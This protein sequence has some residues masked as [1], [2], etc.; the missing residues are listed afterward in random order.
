MADN[1]LQRLNSLCKS[2]KESLEQE[3]V[4]K[5][6]HEEDGQKLEDGKE[7]FGFKDSLSQPVFWKKSRKKKKAQKLLKRNLRLVLV[8]EGNGHF[9]S[10]FVFR[11][12]QQHIQIFNDRIYELAKE[13][14]GKRNP[15]KDDIAF[16]EAQF[17]G[18]FKNGTPLTLAKKPKKNPQ[19][20]FKKFNHFDIL[21]S[22]GKDDYFK[23]LEGEK[24]PFH[25]HIRK[26]NPRDK[27]FQ[28]SDQPYSGSADPDN[29]QNKIEV[30]IV[31]RG[32]PYIESD[33]KKGI[34][35][36][37]YQASLEHQFV[38][39][40]RQWVNWPDFP[41]N[42]NGQDPLLAKGRESLFTPVAKFRQD[43]NKSWNENE[44]ASYSFSKD[45]DFK[46]E[47]I[48]LKAALYFYAPSVHFLK[49]LNG[50]IS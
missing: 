18:R 25:S 43:W 7:H 20:K 27:N 3:D 21:N 9:G 36:L 46:S 28:F 17:M 38:H 16:A 31:R 15:D 4:G 44:R 50:A 12:Y 13:L 37:S 8:P 24:C 45:P 39:I 1:N 33:S 10:F 48:T 47:V 29:P 2:L 11:K 32:I 35:F 19:K 23:D 40:F 22:K 26:V 14:T 34:L 5:V 6:L 41:P 49:S 30:R 42:S